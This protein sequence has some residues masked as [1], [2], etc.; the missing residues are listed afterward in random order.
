MP[1]WDPAAAIWVTTAGPGGLWP[2]PVVS[3]GSNYTCHCTLSGSCLSRSV[4]RKKC[5]RC[6][7]AVQGICREAAQGLGRG[8]GG[9]DW[10]SRQTSQVGDL[11]GGN[12]TSAPPQSCMKTCRTETGADLGVRP[13]DGSFP[14]EVMGEGQDPTLLMREHAQRRS[15]KG[16]HQERVERSVHAAV[17]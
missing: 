16:A 15:C 3:E 1:N 11:E 6:T 7:K 8:E 12:E 2:L 17:V 9:G 10:K 4:S 13:T 5:E 14:T